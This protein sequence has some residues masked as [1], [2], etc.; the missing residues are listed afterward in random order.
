[1]SLPLIFR[2][3]HEDELPTRVRAAKALADMAVQAREAAIL[4]QAKPSPMRNMQLD[5]FVQDS[6]PKFAPPP[7]SLHSTRT[8]QDAQPSPVTV[9]FGTNRQPLER[10]ERD[11]FQTIRIP[12]LLLIILGNF[13]FSLTRIFAEKRFSISWMVLCLMLLGCY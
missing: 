12:I 5:A 9:Y 7:E 6:P 2:L 13:L 11:W 8:A 10:Q 1:M 3:L 4:S